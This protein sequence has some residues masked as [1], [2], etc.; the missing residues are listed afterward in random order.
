MTAEAREALT[1]MGIEPGTHRSRMLELAT[2]AASRRIFTLTKS[3]QRAVQ[4]ALP[5]S[6]ASKVELLDPQGADVPDPIGGPL[7][8][9]RTT[10]AAIERMVKARLK[11]MGIG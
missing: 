9:Y 8:E 4:A 5:A 2:A 3:H 6:E 10:A 1:E 11:E 7:E